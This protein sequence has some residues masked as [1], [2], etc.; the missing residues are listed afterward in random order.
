MSYKILSINPGSTSTK[1]AVYQEETELHCETIDHSVEDLA[2]FSDITDQM[3]F[4]KEMILAS[5]AAHGFQLNELDAVVGRGGMLPPVHAGGYYVNQKMK[6]RIL[7]G[8][9]FAHASNLGAL[10]ADA[11]AEPLGIPA[12]IYD[13][14]A[15]DELHD[16]ARITG[17]PEITRRSFTH[18]LNTKAM[19]R[20]AAASFG[21][22][23]EDMNFVVAH[24]GGGISV[25]VHEKGKIV[26][27]I[28]DDGG[29]FSPERAGSIPLSYI[30]DM[31]FSGKY[32]KPA[33]SKMIRGMGGLKAHL[34]THDCREV[35]KMIA[36]G[37]Q[38]A[39]E[40]YEA[41]AYQIAKGIG[42]ISPV[43]SGNIDAIILTGG[44][45]YSK[46]LTDWVIERV[47]FIA[48]VI[49]MPG[50]NEMESL[51][52]GAL[53]ILRQVETA[54]EYTESIIIR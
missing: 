2:P 22:K 13:S 41:M 45:A 49:L 35:E 25:N 39:R 24:L 16:I 43:L 23:Y 54:R 51:S 27:V 15:S 9:I 48:P 7:Y 1:F 4:R 3:E 46:M 33:M 44:V 32:D 28:T 38:K 26:D 52:L 10:I 8:P 6:D 40:V 19:A 36:D 21:K 42:E 20:K 47:K 31:C 50:E 12:L 18:V 5:F 17:I 11:I 14:V 29:P 53:R 30:V 37:N 34:G